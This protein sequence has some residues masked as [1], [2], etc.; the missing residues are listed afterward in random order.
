MN[1]TEL[2]KSMAAKS[3]L[4]NA[5]ADEAYKAF[6]A[7]IVEAFN[8]DEE[9][10]LMG[11]GTFSLKKKAAREGINPATKEKVQ[12]DASKVPSFKAGKSFKEMFNK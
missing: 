6:V 5:Q 11:F 12:M 1:K 8:L 10:Q 3:G 7:S 4:T 9:V 2:I